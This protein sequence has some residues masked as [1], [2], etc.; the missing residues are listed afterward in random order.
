MEY[1]RESFVADLSGGG[2]GCP[3]VLEMMRRVPRHR[4]VSEALQFNAYKDISLPIGFGQT[5]SRPSVIARMVEALDLRG[6]ER[7]LE[8][9]TGSGYQSAILAGLCGYLV[10]VERIGVLLKRAGELLDSM[11]YRNIGFIH[12]DDF[13]SATGT[14]D[15]VIVAAGADILP[16]D[17]LNKLDEGGRMVIPVSNGSGHTIQKIIKA[18]GHDHTTEDIGEATFVPYITG[19]PA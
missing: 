8:I 11:N 15:A 7:V 18:G 5:I 17:I 16:V 9:G 6:Y 12:S 2:V 1:A 19:K 13:N 3:R 4:F 14:F 10:T